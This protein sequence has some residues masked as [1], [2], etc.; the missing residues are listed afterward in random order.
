MLEDGLPNQVPI[1]R[2]RG[3]VVRRSIA[4]DPKDEPIWIRAQRQPKVNPEIVAAH[5]RANDEIT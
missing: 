4:L 2:I 1:P 3:T 5:L